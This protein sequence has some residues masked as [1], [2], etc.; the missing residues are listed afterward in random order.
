[1][2]PGESKGGQGANKQGQG[3][4]WKFSRFKESEVEW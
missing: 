4:E 1:M 3:E 2:K